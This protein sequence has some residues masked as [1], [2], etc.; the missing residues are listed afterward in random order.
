MKYRTI[1]H[2]ITQ[3]KQTVFFLYQRELKY[4][5][6]IRFVLSPIRLCINFFFVLAHIFFAFGEYFSHVFLCGENGIRDRGVQVVGA[7]I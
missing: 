6:L 2:Q 5:A 3:K 4:S 7:I 1:L